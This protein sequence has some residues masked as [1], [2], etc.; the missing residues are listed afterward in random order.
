MALGADGSAVG[1]ALWY[2]PG[3]KKHS[4][5][6]ALAESLTF[7]PAGLPHLSKAARLQRLVVG[8]W[9]KEEHW[10]LSVLSISPESQRGGYGSA[11]LRPGLEAADRDGTGCWLE[12]QRESNIPF[13]A[14]FGFQLLRKV[15]V[16]SGVPLWLMWRPPA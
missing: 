5:R 11:L 7:L 6:E 12:T 14:R 8:N 2:P 15:E 1:A 9:P 16:E 3:T 4:F 10:Y 13:Y